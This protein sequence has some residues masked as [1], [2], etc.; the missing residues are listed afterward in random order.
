MNML[1]W[2]EGSMLVHSVGQVSVGWSRGGG[3]EEHSCFL[4]VCVGCPRPEIVSS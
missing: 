1:R 2:L 3:A 4:G